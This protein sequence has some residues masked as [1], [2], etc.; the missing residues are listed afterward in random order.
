MTLQ[1]DLTTTG[2]PISLD[3]GTYDLTIANWTSPDPD[4][5]LEL[6]LI[7]G[8][9]TI[10]D[11]WNRTISLDD[12]NRFSSYLAPLTYTITVSEQS[13]LSLSTDDG[14]NYYPFD[15][16]PT[17]PTATVVLSSPG[18][19]QPEAFGETKGRD[20]WFKLG[21]GRSAANHIELSEYLD[22][23]RGTLLE[24][25][26]T[27][28]SAIKLGQQDSITWRVATRDTANDDAV[29]F[30]LDGELVEQ[31]SIS[32]LGSDRITSEFGSGELS[33][34]IYNTGNYGGWSGLT[35]YGLGDVAIA[36]E[37]ETITPE[38]P[39]PEP[40]SD[41]PAAPIAVDL[42]TGEYFG[43][44]KFTDDYVQISTGTRDRALSSIARE[45]GAD[46]DVLT[47]MGI[48][49]GSFAR[50]NTGPGTVTLDWQFLSRDADPFGDKVLIFDGDGQFTEIDLSGL[51][52]T[53][54]G[55]TFTSSTQ[56]LSFETGGEFAIAVLD[57]GDKVGSSYVRVEALS[58]S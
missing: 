12:G 52:D 21:T 8:A 41:E 20:S 48:T 18:L 4:D 27:T 17:N 15:D 2:I 47:D 38:A 57:V 43:D 55:S 39:A 10:S 11:Q 14:F 35:F 40:E 16:A 46:R 54:S 24:L 28:G 6:N 19:S 7:D 30:F 56:Q 26:V 51:T 36:E 37:E 45:L 49:E 1:L 3:P 23:S 31:F 9:I 25:G 29:A 50:F 44:S 22:I 53:T 32:E 42:L 5:S 13:S 34:V 33:A 58:L